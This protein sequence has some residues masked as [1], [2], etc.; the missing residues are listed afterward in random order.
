MKKQNKYLPIP[1]NKIKELEQDVLVK[2]MVNIGTRAS[3]TVEVIK[4]FK[5]GDKVVNIVRKG[6]A[7]APIYLNSTAQHLLTNQYEE[8]KIYKDRYKISKHIKQRLYLAGLV[9]AQYTAHS[10]RATFATR[11][12]SN[13][14]DLV[15]ISTLMNHSNISMT[16]Q[17]IKMDESNLRAGVETLEPNQTIEGMT[18]FEMRKEIVA[19]RK[20][21]LRLEGL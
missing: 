7:L 21:L 3:E 17:Y 15:S 14:V 10:T 6:G 13:G 16:A 1:L 8:L 20:R 4:N 11:L 5:P 19:L 18:E 2:L 12:I 9:G